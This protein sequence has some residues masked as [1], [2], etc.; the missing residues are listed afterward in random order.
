VTAARRALA[1]RLE[2]AACEVGG[3]PRRRRGGPAR[4]R[5]TI[6]ALAVDDHR[7]GHDQPSGSRAG[8]PGEPGPAVPRSCIRRT[9]ARSSKVYAAPDH[10]GQVADH[11]DAGTVVDRL[12]VADV[13]VHELEAQVLPVEGW[14]AGGVTHCSS[15]VEYPHLMTRARECLDYMGSYEAGTAGDQ[16]RMP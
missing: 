9:A 13:A 15:A 10:R 5:R 16:T 4:A 1:S 7:R 14:E 2:P 3:L 12:R 6:G 11:A 8:H